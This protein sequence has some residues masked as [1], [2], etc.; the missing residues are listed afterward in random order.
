[1]HVDANVE[2]E[3]RPKWATTTLQDAGDLFGDPTGTKIT[4][5]YFKEPHISLTAIELMP[6]RNI[7]L[8]QYSYPQSYGEASENPSWESTMQEEYNSLLEN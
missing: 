4:R 8:V 1:L 5:S 3:L 7:F 2:P 6:P